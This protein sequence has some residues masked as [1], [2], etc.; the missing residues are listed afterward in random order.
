M[1]ADSTHHPHAAAGA[2]PLI[3]A[4]LRISDL[5]PAV[6]PLDG[7][8]TRDR[9]GVGLTA[10]DAAALEHALRIA[11]A[12]SGR[13]VAVCVGPRVGRTGARTRWPPLGVTV[14]RLPADDEGDEHRYVDEL[15][16]DERRLA[17]TL[18]AAIRP[19]RPS[20]PGP[21][22]RPLG[23]SRHRAPCPPTWPTSSEPPR[24]SGW[25]P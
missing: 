5:R 8:V 21:V 9:L 23:R 7:A 18:V 6:D 12:W 15:A 10:A 11:E 20:R 13:V 1:S 4:C 2:G 22:R 19:V 14:V 3:V 17:R 16:G 25:S 24:P